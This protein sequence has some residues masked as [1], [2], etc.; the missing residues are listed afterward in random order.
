M[1][2][3]E[4]ERANHTGIAQP[5]SNGKELSPHEFFS[6]D[7]GE[8]G[9]GRMSGEDRDSVK[10]SLSFSESCVSNQKMHKLV[11]KECSDRAIMTELLSKLCSSQA[12]KN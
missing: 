11:L 7:W 8:E 1:H 10:V 9:R 5:I 4:S 12:L 3:S 6:S 2:Y